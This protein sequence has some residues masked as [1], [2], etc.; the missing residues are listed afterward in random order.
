MTVSVGLRVSASSPYGLAR[1]CARNPVALS[2]L[3]YRP[4]DGT[5]TYHCDKPTGPTAGSETMARYAT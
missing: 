2:R 4:D 5:V 1:Y 3:E